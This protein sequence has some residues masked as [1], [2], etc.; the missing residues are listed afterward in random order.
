MMA[1]LKTQDKSLVNMDHIV[2]IG[3]YESSEKDE[4]RVI[5][6]CVDGSAHILVGDTKEMAATFMR[7]L[8]TWIGYTESRVYKPGNMSHAGSGMIDKR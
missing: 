6:Q 5:A 3:R 7:D 4:S 2:S 8:A 1:W